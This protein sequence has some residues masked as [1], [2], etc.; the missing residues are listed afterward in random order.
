MNKA[1]NVGLSELDEQTV[2]SML[3]PFTV[4]Q[5]SPLG[6]LTPPIDLAKFHVTDWRSPFW[7]GWKALHYIFYSLIKYT[8]VRFL[9]HP[10]ILQTTSNSRV[11]KEFLLG[12]T[13]L[14]VN[15]VAK[16]KSTLRVPRGVYSCTSCYHHLAPM[17][18]IFVC[19]FRK[20]IWIKPF[21]VICNKITLNESVEQQKNTPKY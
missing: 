5:V 18:P 17:K 8:V 6:T 13:K 21:W 12:E 4:H 3:Y 1:F 2:F 14:W 10:P 16:W 9:G 7:K 19:W 15:A 20:P 11:N